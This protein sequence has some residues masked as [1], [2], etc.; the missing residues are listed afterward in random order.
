M[1]MLTEIHAKH[2]FQR[3]YSEAMH[4]HWTIS[5]VS[6]SKRYSSNNRNTRMIVPFFCQNLALANQGSGMFY[7]TLKTKLPRC[8]GYC[9]VFCL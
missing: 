1:S 7:T 8:L 5:G 2:G 6:K 9:V 4:S 3:L